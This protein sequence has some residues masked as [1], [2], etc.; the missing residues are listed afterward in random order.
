MKKKAKLSTKLM[1]GGIA[2]VLIPVLVIGFM[3]FQ[4]ASQALREVSSDRA[5]TMAKDVA[6]TVQTVIGAELKFMENVASSQVGEDSSSNLQRILEKSG[7]AY[8]TVF[9]ADLSGKIVADGSSGEYKNISV[10]DR[11]Y[12]KAALESKS[13]I[14]A[15]AASKKT[16]KPIIPIASPVFSDQ[17]KVIG[18]VTA[19][20]KVD[21]MTREIVNRKIGKSGYIFLVD[22]TS[23]IIVHPKDEL[24]LAK[25]ISEF[26]GMEDI[27][28]RTLKK[29]EG[30]E[31][32]VFQGIPKIAGFSPV[33][34]TGWSVVATQDEDEFLNSVYVI[35]KIIFLVTVGF[36][37]V[38]I[39]AVILFARG[40]TRPI[41]R[42]VEGLNDGAE[43]VAEASAH[44]SSSSQSL[45]EGASEQAA[46]IEET[47]SSLEEISSMTR[48]NA[49][50]AQQANRLM[51]ND[52]KESYRI[53]SDKMALME[54]AVNDSVKASDETAKIIKT[55]DEI[56]F[57]TNLLALNAAV[58]A[59]RAGESGAGF[60]VVADEVRNLA[61]RAAEAAKT[62]GELIAGSSVQI[63]QAA[64]LF[65][66]V[67]QNL[68]ENRHIAKKV[69]ELVGEIAAASQEQA[70]G[71]EQVN[72]AVAEMDKVVQQN[73]ATAE[74][75]AAAAEEMN[76]QAEQMKSYVGDLVSTI[77]GTATDSSKP[78]SEKRG[79]LSK[80]TRKIPKTVG[81][82]ETAKFRPGNS[83]KAFAE[84]F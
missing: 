20:L 65:S 42:V 31:D 72:Q 58:E 82:P 63:K 60:A 26:K 45:A 35:R 76:A 19:L 51:A 54:S 52:A 67:S 33:T 21:F 18:I 59:A 2:L 84:D 80:L 44:V 28:A 22:D 16:G 5:L 47:S 71:V 70:L 10:G 36:L 13:N 8:E 34:L 66:E 77:G 25:K 74:E 50:N 75:S 81:Y 83:G 29:D 38:A 48:Q 9:F 56:A 61:L 69:T 64:Q 11:D 46:A 43:Q 15:V 79:V 24:V 27:T 7:G 57:Q 14:G 6:Q 41:M 55:I 12:F 68:S 32:Y 1:I 62:T 4:K 49:D 3:S 17:K 30:V 37:I 39:V 78:V 53:I 40:I 73:A 23:R